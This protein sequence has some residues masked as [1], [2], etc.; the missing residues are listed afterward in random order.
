MPYTAFVNQCG[1]R[2]CEDHIVELCRHDH[3]SRS[4]A[5]R[6]SEK[7]LARLKSQHEYQNPFGQCHPGN[8]NCVPAEGDCVMC[9]E[10][11]ASV[12]HLGEQE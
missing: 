1:D 7:M 9:G 11:K 3:R 12:Q 10:S 8:P 6:C 4:E 2:K 5:L